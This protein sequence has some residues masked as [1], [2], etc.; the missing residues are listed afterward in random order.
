MFMKIKISCPCHCSYVL[1]ENINSDKVVCPNCGNEYPYSEKLTSILKL[2]KEIPD[3]DN[4]SN[5]HSV[6]VISP[7]E[8]MSNHQ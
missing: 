4:F 5:E 1:N 8:D 6:E 3:G 2:A 7:S